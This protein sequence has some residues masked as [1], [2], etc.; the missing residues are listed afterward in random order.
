MPIRQKINAKETL[1]ILMVQRRSIFKG[2]ST[3][4]KKSLFY[5]QK[6][7]LCISHD[8]LK[9]RAVLQVV[10]VHPLKISSE[11]EDEEGG[12]TGINDVMLYRPK[13]AFNYQR[14]SRTS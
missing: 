1:F 12:S 9:R 2:K 7:H 6:L 10:E 8:M 13:I 5:L 4:A 14:D 11:E 3:A